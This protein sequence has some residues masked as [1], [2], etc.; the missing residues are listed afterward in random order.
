MVFWSTIASTKLS[1][2]IQVVTIVGSVVTACRAVNGPRGRSVSV[3]RDT[4]IPNTTANGMRG[5]SRSIIKTAR[6]AANQNA[7]KSKASVQRK[8]IT[9]ES[10]SNASVNK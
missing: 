1:V 2:A 5:R 6:S 4:T 3:D 9:T 8:T 7:A 10:A